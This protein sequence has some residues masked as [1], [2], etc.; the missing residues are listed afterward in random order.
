MKISDYIGETTAYDK[1]AELE[2]KKPKSW[3][4]S[5]SAFANGT[6]G[7]L[8]FG[9]DDNDKLVGIDDVQT[10]SEKISEIIKDKMDPVP[11]VDMQIHSENGLKFIVLNVLSGSETPYYYVGDGNRIAFVRIGN[12]SETANATELKRLVLKGS[13]KSYDS[14]VTNNKFSD[15]AF[16]KLKSVYKMKT[17]KELTNEDFISFGLADDKGMLTNAGLLLADDSPVYH[18]RLFCTR[19]YGLDMTSGVM[20]AIDDKEFSG[21]L[22]SLLQNGV[23]FI[24]LNTKKRWKKTATSRLEMPEYP[25]RAITEALVNA[26]IH[27]DY[28]EV[29]SE[30]HIDI[31]DNRI[32]IFSPGGMCDGSFVQELNTNN[33]PSRRRNPVIADVFSR[34]NYM[35]RRGSGFKKINGDY[36]ESVN[37]TDELAPV[38]Y[39]DNSTF[40]ITLYNLNYNAPIESDVEIIDEISDKIND[41]IND[42]I[43]FSSNENKVLELIIHDNSITQP[44]ISKELNVS[45]S[46]VSRAIKKLKDNGYIV[47]SGSN[48]DGQWIVKS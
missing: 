7:A 26:L 12:R 29:G 11:Q 36:K 37:Y 34:M 18:S 13:G 28:L 21:S 42:K 16:T 2:I 1:K 40:R 31:F 41:K 14:I 10:T 25:E 35:E 17:H 30:V 6:G 3:L 32:E 19:W 44:Q 43:K 45:E 4:K 24:N 23:E 39:S 47:R 20:D 8:I 9:V 33:I 48:K 15:F 38:Y 5:V 27:R 46:T 22:I